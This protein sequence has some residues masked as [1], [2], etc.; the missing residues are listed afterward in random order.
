MPH[1]H[2]RTPSPCVMA[3]LGPAIHDLAVLVEAKSWMAG[4]RPAMTQGDRPRAPAKATRENKRIGR[5]SLFRHGP[6]KP[7]HDGLWEEWLSPRTGIISAGALSA[8]RL[9]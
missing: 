5:L 9:F 8:P 4:T 2:G 1:C 7:R 6:D 3:G